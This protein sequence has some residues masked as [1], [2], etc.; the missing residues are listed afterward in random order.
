[1]SVVHKCVPMIAA[2]MCVPMI[3]AHMCVPMIAAHKCVPVHVEFMHVQVYMKLYV[4][5]SLYIHR[6]NDECIFHGH[7][8][9]YT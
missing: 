9:V 5:T 3:A 1:M 4:S 2:H 6:W 7:M 8:S